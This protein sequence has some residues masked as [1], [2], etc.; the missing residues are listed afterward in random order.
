M[1]NESVFKVAQQVAVLLFVML[2]GIYAKKRK[3]IDDHSTQSLSKLLLSVTQCCLIISSFQV[4]Y[5]PELL[6][7]GLSVTLI[8]TVIHLSLI[9]LCL[10]IFNMVSDISKRKIYRFG[11]MFGNCGFLGFPVLDA[12]FGDIG[13]FYGAFFTLVF[14]IIN[15][16]YGVYMLSA[17]SSKK[18]F[19]PSQLKKIINPG[20]VSTAIGII[21]FAF[22]IKIPSPLID[23]IDMVGDMT[24]P[25]SMI[26]VGCLISDTKFGRIF[27]NP[28]TY[29]FCF[30]KLLFFPFIAILICKYINLPETLAYI[31]IVMTATPS[32]TVT[33][34]LPE[35][36]GGDSLLGAEIVGISTIVSMV[37]IPFMIY[38]ANIIL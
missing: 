4:D 21:L 2:C 10:F 19:D 9:F 28:Y 37:T 17:D 18:F 3:Y 23:G 29:Y 34:A 33:A 22:R 30:L 36:Y 14:H 26:V 16:T 13:V 35:V 12:M 20:T 1:S 7:E 27:K 15:W 38:L 8:S 31:A 25:L 32:A 11:T 24:F 6:N 5:T